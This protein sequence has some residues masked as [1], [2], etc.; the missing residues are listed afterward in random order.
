MPTKLPKS[1]DPRDRDLYISLFLAC[2]ITVGLAAWVAT[3]YWAKYSP[4]YKAQPAVAP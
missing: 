3:P 2:L 1:R 4:T